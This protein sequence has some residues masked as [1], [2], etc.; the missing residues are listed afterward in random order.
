MK[1]AEAVTEYIRILDHILK[2]YFA[3]LEDLP[4]AIEKMEKAYISC[5]KNGIVVI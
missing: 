4:T 2:I 1:I 5:L 3:N